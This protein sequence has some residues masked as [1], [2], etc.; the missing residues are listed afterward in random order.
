MDDLITKKQLRKQM[1]KRLGDMS[2]ELFKKKCARIRGMLFASMIWKRSTR[3][4][5]TI[6]VHREVETTAIITKAWAEGKVVAVPKCDSIHKA[7]TFYKI[8]SFR[9]L[10]FGFSGL[11]E[12]KPAETA[13]MA[14]DALDLV[15][16]PGIAFDHQGNRIGYGGGYYDR[17]LAD[18]KG[19]TLSL[20]LEEQLL[21]Y[22]PAEPFDIKIRHL[23]TDSASW[24]PIAAN[25]ND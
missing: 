24:D 23:I 1:L 16:V 5:I 20:L 12:P 25:E 3:I 17:F 11:M 6:S 9:Q 19:E 21:G 13:P 2:M 14:A 4:A 8:E 10:E 15:I 7:L 18:Y 22:I